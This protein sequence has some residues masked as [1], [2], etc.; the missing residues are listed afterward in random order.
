MKAQAR[1]L[2]EA[3]AGRTLH[4]MFPMVSEPWEYEDAR[5]LFEEQRAWLIGRGKSVAGAVR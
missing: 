3:S 4:V 2:L 1:A 5:T